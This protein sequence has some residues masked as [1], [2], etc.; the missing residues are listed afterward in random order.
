MSRVDVALV[1]YARVFVAGVNREYQNDAWQPKGYTTTMKVRRNNSPFSLCRRSGLG[2]AV[3]AYCRSQH[4]C[5]YDRYI[6]PLS[7]LS[8]IF[9]L[10][11][12]TTARL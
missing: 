6:N 5:H 2:R 1:G 7:F 10:Y 12:S 4:L 9:F 11:S 3:S 8:T